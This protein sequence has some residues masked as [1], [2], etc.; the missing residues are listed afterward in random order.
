[1]AWFKKKTDPISEHER[2]LAAIRDRDAAA[3]HE[4]IKADIG[5]G[6]GL[7]GA[8]DFDGGSSAGR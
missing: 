7:I 5:D 1:M 4:A 3:L 6:M 2:A 8:E